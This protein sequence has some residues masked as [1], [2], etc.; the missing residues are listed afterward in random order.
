[1][2]KAAPKTNLRIVDQSRTM[3]MRSYDFACE[4]IRMRIEI[5]SPDEDAQSW[6]VQ[7]AIRSEDKVE[8]ASAGETGATRTEALRM[9]A[10]NLR[11]KE[12]LSAT[13]VFDW[14]AVEALLTDVHAL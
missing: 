8:V 3:R 10:D 7:A 4:G 11:G 13:G 6:R 9:V 5:T 14:T 1:M 12:P 2:K